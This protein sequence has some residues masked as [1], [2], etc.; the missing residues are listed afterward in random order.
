MAVV[1]SLI[2]VYDVHCQLWGVKVSNES[3]RDYVY[4]VACQLYQ[5]MPSGFWLYQN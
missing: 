3:V 4:W 2:I 1:I 5:T